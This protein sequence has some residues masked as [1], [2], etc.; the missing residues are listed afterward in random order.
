MWLCAPMVAAHP[1]RRKLQRR[2]R[3]V[4]RRRR[5]C[6]RTRTWEPTSAATRSWRT[7]GLGCGTSSERRARCAVP[8]P[9]FTCII[10]H[11][12]PLPPT[13]LGPSPTPVAGGR[14]TMLNSMQPVMLCHL[15]GIISGCAGCTG[16]GC[17][18]HRPVLHHPHIAHY[19]QRPHLLQGAGPQRGARRVCG[20]HRRHGAAPIPRLRPIPALPR[21]QW[22]LH[23]AGLFLRCT[24]GCTAA[25]ACSLEVC[26][27]QPKGLM[28]PQVGLVNTHYVYLPIPIVISAPRMVSTARHRPTVALSVVMHACFTSAGGSAEVTVGF[29]RRLFLFPQVDPNGKMYNRLR[30]AIGQPKFLPDQ[31]AKA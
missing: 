15:V 1:G 25:A 26:L 7:W 21:L 14:S 20:L 30:A 24:E 12:S 6:C 31:D 10:P 9:V 23:S 17:Q 18:V 16:G 19:Q 8:P 13:P 29:L 11:S 27:P 3:G 22:P 2:T 5:N 4:R 28:P